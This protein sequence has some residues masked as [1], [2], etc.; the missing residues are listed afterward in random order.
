M[1]TITDHWPIIATIIAIANTWA[2]FA[3]GRYLDK[4]KTATANPVANQANAVSGVINWRIRWLIALVQA[5]AGWVAL[6]AIQLVWRSKPINA[7]SVVLLA[8]CGLSFL[9]LSA[10]PWLARRLVSLPVT[11]ESGMLLCWAIY[12]DK[13]FNPHCPVDKTPL[14]FGSHALESGKQGTI[15]H[16][17]SCGI[18]I[19]IW[20]SVHG[21]LKLSDAKA[22]LRSKLRPI[23]N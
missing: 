19:P 20:D 15:L 11:R 14:S 18:D 6:V 21:P 7:E 16:C 9:S 10:L 17:P 5:L 2:I 3:F 8:A 1:K 13:S 23:S 22:Q 4:K 12:W